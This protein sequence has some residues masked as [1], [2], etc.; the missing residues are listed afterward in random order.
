MAIF[1]DTFTTGSNVD[2]A[3]HTPD[4]GTSWTKLWGSNALEG[5][6]A[7]AAT[8]RAT[9][10]LG[11]SQGAI[12]TANA[13]YPSADYSV[14]ATYIAALT[15]DD[16]AYLLARCTDQENFYAVYLMAGTGNTRI[17][18]KV[19]G[20][21]TALGS[22]F[23]GPAA[24]DV[25]KLEVIGSNI[26]VYYNGVQQQA[27]TD[28]DLTATGKAG[29]AIG[30]AA[31]LIN[32][33]DDI[34]T[35]ELDSFV[36]TDL[37]TSVQSLTLPFLASTNTLYAATLAQN[38]SLP[39]IASAAAMYTPTT[40][41]NLA[42]PHLGS[43]SSV[44]VPSMAQS[45]TLPHLASQTVLHAPAVAGPGVQ[46]V[47][48]PFILGSGALYGLALHQNISLP[49]VPSGSQALAP[50]VAQSLGLPFVSS[51][52]AAYSPV[53]AQ[54]ITLPAIPAGGLLHTPLV[55]AEQGVTLPRISSTS[56]AYAM[57][58]ADAAR[59]SG[60][61][62]LRRRRISRRILRT[63]RTQPEAYFLLDEEGMPLLHEDGAI[64][65]LE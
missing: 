5:L 24:N 54:S 50:S 35:T 36:V 31:E 3:S 12:Y 8:G 61:R 2:L 39:N 22:G 6:N 17:Y 4:V 18:K 21:F 42:L 40:A 63:L 38:V 64:I 56:T 19:A 44:F 1:Q 52:A 51:T 47:A 65:E 59:L 10:T 16:T 34:G 49:A 15:G 27:V 9:G 32:P 48:L 28:S 53:L 11:A 45:I 57:M 60:R 14:E 55:A 26:K 46:T 13:T 41:L 58:L 20:T 33:T 25:I 30:G 23:N 62:I 43:A 7:V 37:G 29:L